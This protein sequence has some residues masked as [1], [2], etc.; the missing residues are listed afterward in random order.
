MIETR[1]RERLLNTLIYFSETRFAGKVKLF[2]LLY[3][4][5]FL[6]FQETGYSVTGLK[7]N[8]WKM[9]P[10][11]VELFDELKKPKKDFIDSLS[12]RKKK[13]LNGWEAQILVPRKEFNDIYFSPFQ[14]ELMQK[15]SKKY[16]NSNAEDMTADSHQE[17]GCWDEVYNQQKND[18]GNIPY[19]MIL[20]RRNNDRD[21]EMLELSKEYEA[22]LHNF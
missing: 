2:K 15:I 12:K 17:F 21:K 9:G 8:A 14:I 7:Y 13:Y 16:F 6:H 10:V 18:G 11:P 20:Q 5:D 22:L 1:N 4:L 19:E 3:A